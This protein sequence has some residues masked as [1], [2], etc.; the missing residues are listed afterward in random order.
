MTSACT[1]PRA[2]SFWTRRIGTTNAR[3]ERDVVS[4]QKCGRSAP[5]SLPPLNRVART[6]YG[7]RRFILNRFPFSTMYLTLDA[8]GHIVAVA[9]HSRKPG[10]WRKR[11]KDIR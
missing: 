10:Y 4:K 9:H 5:G 3:R 8:T 2:G 6:F 11:L 1:Q 7:T